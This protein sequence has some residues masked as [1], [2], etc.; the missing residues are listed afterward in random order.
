M[1]RGRGPVI[2]AVVGERGRAQPGAWGWLVPR[3]PEPPE[4]SE[5]RAQSEPP[6]QR[7][8]SEPSELR[9]PPEASELRAPPGASEPPEQSGSREPPESREQSGLREPPEQTELREQ[10]LL[11]RRESR[12]PQVTSEPQAAAP[13]ARPMGLASLGWSQRAESLAPWRGLPGR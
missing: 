9:E 10:A 2:A 7:A 13:R 6:E 3:A 11:V 5:L 1:W 4:A 12:V 8:Q